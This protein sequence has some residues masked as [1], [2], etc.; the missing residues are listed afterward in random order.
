[1]QLQLIR[2]ATMKI[3]YAGR[4]LLTDPLLAP[5]DTYDGFAG[6]AR[7]PT[8]D[9]PVPPTEICQGVE[10]VLISHD[11]PDHIDPV[12]VEALPK[13][14]PL[15]CQ[16]GEAEKMQARGFNTVTVIDEA[17]RWEKITLT[18]TGGAHGRGAILK[19]MGAVSGFVLQAENEPTLYWVG[20]SVWCEAVETAIATHRPDIIITHSGGA[21]LPGFDP[22]L[23]DA[24]E[25]LCLVE[26]APDAV[27]VAIHMEALDHCPVTRM[28][29]RQRADD[30]GIA[31][32]RLMIPA[33]GEIIRLP[34][35]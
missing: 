27:V 1:M 29:L 10:A 32:S 30:A 8:V 22:I 2:N 20:D 3:T 13:S 9:L 16:P 26:A 18:R 24:H 11:H 25:T 6:I 23:M 19:R 33:D 31:P 21:T 15:F 34:P 28:E 17:H 7:N 4:T 35:S 5:K 12:A 14:L